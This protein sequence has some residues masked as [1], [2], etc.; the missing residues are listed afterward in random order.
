MTA[1]SS[2]ATRRLMPQNRDDWPALV[3]AANPLPS[4]LV[5]DVTAEVKDAF[6][7]YNQ[8]LG[9]FSTQDQRRVSDAITKAHFENDHAVFGPQACVIVD[10]PP[11]AGKTYAVL[12]QA[13]KETR[14]IWEA[15]PYD[16]EEPGHHRSTPWVYIEIPKYGQGFSILSAICMFCG[17]IV[18]ERRDKNATT[19]GFLLR[20]LAPQ[21]GLRGV[22][23]D[24]S[25]GIAGQVNKQAR[26][27]AD[28]LKNSITGIPA[29]V[30]II[31]TGL[32]ESGVLH[33][34]AGEQVLLRGA[35]WVDVGDWPAPGVSAASNLGPW[36]RLAAS[37]NEHL[38]FPRPDTRCLLNQR[39]VL[40][41]L[42]DGARGRPGLAIM[43]VKRAARHAIDTDSHLDLSALDATYQATMDRVG[44][45]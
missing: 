18:A 3:R 5:E 33:G 20:D 40:N 19:L 39:P 45:S 21:I 35:A 7:R 10:G 6:N 22:I 27:L 8:R 9:P 12:T 44:T 31:G 41:R 26:S 34:I 29:T 1:S 17:A 24:D 16:P 38:A 13:M 42:V 15:L 32:R 30:V 23:I 43:W 4:T 25:H 36:E 11:L 2:T 37:L 14:A 28:T